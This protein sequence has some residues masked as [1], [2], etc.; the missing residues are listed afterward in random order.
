MSLCQLHNAH[1]K[2]NENVSAV[3]KATFNQHKPLEDEPQ[4]LAAAPYGRLVRQQRLPTAA[5]QQQHSVPSLG[6]FLNP[7]KRTQ[8]TI[9]T[10]LHWVLNVYTADYH[11]NHLN[12]N[13][14]I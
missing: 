3:T 4:R 8:V 1:G 9:T 5:V 12:K 14:T 11:D 7:K 2:T 6:I 10:T 13:N